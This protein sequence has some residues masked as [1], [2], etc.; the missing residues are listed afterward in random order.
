MRK[1]RE[2]ME[3][4][5]LEEKVSLCQGASFWDTREIEEKGIPRITMSDGPHGLRR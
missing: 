3:E 5:T 1:I 4:L 2:L